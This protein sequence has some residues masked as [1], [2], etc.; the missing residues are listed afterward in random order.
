VFPYG[1]AHNVELT[2]MTK[3]YIDYTDGNFSLQKV[4]QD[5]QTNEA[6]EIPDK[7]W[8]AYQAHCHECRTWYWI[9]SKLDSLNWKE[10]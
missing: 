8:E 10:L 4:E 6:I 7:L 5:W 3:V 2:Q 1:L 9:I